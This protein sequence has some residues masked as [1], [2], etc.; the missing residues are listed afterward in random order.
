MRFNK[1]VFIF[2]LFFANI[3]LAQQ[4]ELIQFEETTHDFGTVKE[5]DGPIVYE[6]KFI[7]TGSDSIR[8]KGVKASCG[9]TTPGWSKEPIAPGESGYIKAQYNTRNRPGSFNKSLTVTTDLPTNSVKRLYIKGVV[10]P[11][12]KTIEEELPTLMGGLRV[13]YNSF[14]LGRVYTKEEPTVKEYEVYNASEESITFSSQ[15]EKPDYINISFKPE[16]LEPKASGKIIVSYQGSLRNDWGFVTDNIVIYTDEADDVNRKSFT[17]YA[18]IEEYF[19]PISNDEYLEAPHLTI[20]EVI[21]DFGS[22]GLDEKASHKF[23][24]T[25]TGKQDLNI[26][27]V[28]SSCSCT[29]TKLKKNDVKPGESVELEVVFDSTGRRGNQ[30]KSVTIFCNDPRKPM[31]R[32]TVKGVVKVD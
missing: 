4:T 12:P 24:L 1:L 13:N 16:V 27:A 30:Q 32:V 14:N 15:I 21:H 31:Q 3:G 10:T 18:T 25:N 2:A 20:D 26:R 5:E 23:V 28:K 22:I 6:F 7:N 17:V 19:A 9:C 29:I 8:I 11:K